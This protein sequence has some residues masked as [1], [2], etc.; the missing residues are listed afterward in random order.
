[1]ALGCSAFDASQGRFTRRFRLAIAVLVTTM[2]FVLAACDEEEHRAVAPGSVSNLATATSSDDGQDLTEEPGSLIDPL[3]NGVSGIELP[4]AHRVYFTYG[5]DIW[6]A[7]IDSDPSPVITERSVAG[8]SPS[9]TGHRLAVLGLERNDDDEDRSVLSLVLPS[10]SPILDLS[11]FEQ[12]ER[13]EGMSPVESIALT[14]AGTSLA[15]THRNGALTVASLDGQVQQFIHP[16]ERRRP[17]NLQWSSDG[18]ILAFLDPWLPNEPSGLYVLVPETAVRQVLIGVSEKG[19]GVEAA[20]WVPGTSYLVYTKSSGS[21]IP[22]GGDVFVVNALTGERELLLSSNEIAPVAGAVDLAV[23]PDGET[24]ALTAFVPG[25]EHPEFAGLWTVNL[26]TG[27]RERV[28]VDRGYTV[29]DIWWLGE[30]LLYRTVDE[31]RT[32]LPGAY[33]GLEE[34]QLVEYDPDTG[35]KRERLLSE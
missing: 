21:T 9:A 27:D 1:M 3:E 32:R 11:E 14:P 18:Q 6:Q 17:G 33:T 15:M 2:A 7:P 25:D 10:G 12:A 4:R 31:P 8:F 35:V 22:H 24:V 26:S 19:H 13:L 34:F 16:E 29:T 5:G 20:K 28:P 30:N 23:S